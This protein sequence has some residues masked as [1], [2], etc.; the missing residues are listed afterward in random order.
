[1]QASHTTHTQISFTGRLQAAFIGRVARL[2]AAAALAAG[3]LPLMQMAQPALAA[4]S[5]TGTVFQ[6]F[7]SNGT[8]EHRRMDH[9]PGQRGRQSN[10]V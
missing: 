9:L 4:G 2:V 3:S 6:D 5:I 8:R 7:N 10:R 1:M